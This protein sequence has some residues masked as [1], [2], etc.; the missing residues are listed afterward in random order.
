MSPDGKIIHTEAHSTKALKHEKHTGKNNGTFHVH[1]KHQTGYEQK[2]KRLKDHNHQFD[3]K[4]REYELACVH[5]RHYG[6]FEQT[7]FFL[8]DKH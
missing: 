4:V 7:L 6:S 5:T 3:G 2:N 8:D 1:V